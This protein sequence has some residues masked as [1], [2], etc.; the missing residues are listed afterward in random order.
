VVPTR[1]NGL[2]WGAKGFPGPKRFGPVAQYI[3]D[4][5]HP[6]D[7]FWMA[8]P[9]ASTKMID[10]ALKLQMAYEVC[11]PR[12]DVDDPRRFGEEWRRFLTVVQGLL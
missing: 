10:Q 5:S 8:H 11:A 6:V 7:H 2:Y 9:E 3:E 4:H 1:I 12:M